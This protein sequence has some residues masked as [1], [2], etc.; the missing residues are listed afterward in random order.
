MK[1]R[2]T[3]LIDNVLHLTCSR[4]KAWQP[5]TAFNTTFIRGARYHRSECRSCDSAR[6]RVSKPEPKR[7]Y[8]SPSGMADFERARR[9]YQAAMGN[10]NAIVP[11][12]QARQL[13]P[14]RA[15]FVPELED[16]A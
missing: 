16:V 13:H 7:R 3:Q 10:R 9:E 4:C 2:P 15:V 8:T 6:R 11:M 12:A 14:P 5:H 1:T